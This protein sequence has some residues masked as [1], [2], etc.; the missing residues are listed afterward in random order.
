MWF[1]QMQEYFS[2]NRQDEKS[3]NL[4][5]KQG[6]ADNLDIFNVEIGT[7]ES[8]EIQHDA[9]KSLSIFPYTYL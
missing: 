8:R 5:K 7:I 4:G 6:E 1:E 9:I 2:G 3:H